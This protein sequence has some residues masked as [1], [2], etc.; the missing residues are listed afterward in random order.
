MRFCYSS[1]FDSISSFNSQYFTVN[2]AVSVIH[3]LYGLVAWQ[4]VATGEASFQI[5]ME[6]GLQTTFPLVLKPQ[7]DGNP[8]V[9]FSSGYVIEIEKLPLAM[10]HVN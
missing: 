5:C 10:E 7:L 6:I 2:A 3:R 8:P 9:L 4:F 1:S